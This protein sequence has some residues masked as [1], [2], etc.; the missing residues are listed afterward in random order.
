[1]KEITLIPGVCADRAR[2]KIRFDLKSKFKKL[3][4][5]LIREGFSLSIDQ[6]GFLYGEARGT[7]EEISRLL[8]L[9]RIKG[10]KSEN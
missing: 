8:E 2:I 10:F 6:E 4:E 7:F 5:T 9:L 1:M 3:I